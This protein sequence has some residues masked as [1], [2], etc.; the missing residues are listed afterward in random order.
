MVQV[1]TTLQWATFAIGDEP[2]IEQAIELMRLMLAAA[3]ER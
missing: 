3:L 2:K 1:A